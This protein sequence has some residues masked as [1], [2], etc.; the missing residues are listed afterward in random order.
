MTSVCLGKRVTSGAA[1]HDACSFDWNSSNTMASLTAHVCGAA[2]LVGNHSSRCCH[3]LPRSHHNHGAPVRHVLAANPLSSS[4]QQPTSSRRGVLQRECW[5]HH[6]KRKL[7][8]LQ[9][10]TVLVDMQACAS[11]QQQRICWS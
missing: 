10:L 3:V 6:C 7:G 9:G 5:A 4:W 1:Q 11:L 2:P 8:M